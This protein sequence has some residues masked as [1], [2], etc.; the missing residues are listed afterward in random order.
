MSQFHKI[1]API[2][3]LKSPE[4]IISGPAKCKRPKK[5]DTPFFSKYRRNFFDV[6]TAG[7]LQSPKTKNPIVEKL[8]EK[9]GLNHHKPA[10]SIKKP[11]EKYEVVIHNGAISRIT[12]KRKGN[13][14]KAHKFIRR[15]GFNPK[16]LG[17]TDGNG[18]T[19]PDGVYIV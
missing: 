13:G 17:L 14:E 4:F 6:D 12:Q 10:D 5:G 2:P 7:N 19:K 15:D 9:M 18:N 8:R 1:K 3:S 11:L 16:I